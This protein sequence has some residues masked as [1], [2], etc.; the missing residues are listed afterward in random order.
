[1]LAEILTE[2]VLPGTTVVPS[3]KVLTRRPTSG[4]TQLAALSMRSSGLT[5]RLLVIPACSASSVYEVT[6]ADDGVYEG[7]AQQISK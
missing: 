5:V 2:Y 7:G 4:D 6:A 3:S 1:M